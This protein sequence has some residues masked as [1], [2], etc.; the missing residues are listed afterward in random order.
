MGSLGKLLYWFA[1]L[2]LYLLRQP[3]FGPQQTS[4]RPM[5]DIQALR[6]G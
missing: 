5:P 2:L 3:D 1:V 4:L 6:R